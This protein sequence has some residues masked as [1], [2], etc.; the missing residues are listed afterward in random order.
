MRRI[1]R[2]EACCLKRQRYRETSLLVTLFAKESGII[3]CIARGA[4]R[5]RSRLAAALDRLAFSSI[6]YY[7]REDRQL[8][9]LSDAVLIRSFAGVARDPVKFV[10]ACQLAEVCL[11]GIRPYDPNPELFHLLITYLGELD[12]GGAPTSTL[13][14]S[15]LLKAASFLGFRP[16]LSRCVAC[17]GRLSE[18]SWFDAS[19][20]GILCAA[21]STDDSH[22]IRLNEKERQ[23]LLKL[24]FTPAA[25]LSRLAELPIHIP[26]LALNFVERHLQPLPLNSFRCTDGFIPPK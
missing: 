12:S 5:T 25:K 11:R 8:Y 10:A 26:A 3:T 14:S 6:I 16:E 17:A 4:R 23:L 24:I 20:G 2:T 1:V 13:V 9:N 18:A 22:L 21:C 19:R 7:S 15:F